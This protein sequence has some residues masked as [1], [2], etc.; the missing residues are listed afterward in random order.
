MSDVLTTL[1][2]DARQSLL[3][4]I[5][6]V[7]GRNDLHEAFAAWL[8]P[9]VVADLGIDK[10]ADLAAKAAGA[11]RYYSHVAVL[12]VTAQIRP[13]GDKEKEALA[14]GLKWIVNR[15][16]VVDGTPMGFCM[17]GVALAAIILGAK[18]SGD[19]GIWATT[20]EW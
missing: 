1:I 16:P 13:L 12:A 3:R 8:V 15:D 7:V 5:A 11:E 17:D 18:A 14:T 4:E 19:H 2:D 20:C 9:G 6:P 10:A